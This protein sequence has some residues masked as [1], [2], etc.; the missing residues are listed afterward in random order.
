M[1]AALPPTPPAEVVVHH[2]AHHDGV[3]VDVGHVAHVDVLDPGTVTGV[4]TDLGL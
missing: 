1:A 3:H 4:I 2:S